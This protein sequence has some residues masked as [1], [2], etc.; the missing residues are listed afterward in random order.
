MNTDT[1][2]NSIRNDITSG[3]IE[4]KI[5]NNMIVGYNDC[6]IYDEIYNNKT[7]YQPLI[8]ILREVYPPPE[9]EINGYVKD[10]VFMIIIAWQD[11]CCSIF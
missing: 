1:K 7:D 2:I 3:L 9:F 11:V 8:N 6:I 10:D 4:L 5:Y